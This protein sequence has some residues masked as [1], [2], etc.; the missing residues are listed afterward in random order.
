MKS[1]AK[2][3]IAQETTPKNDNSSEFKID[4][5]FLNRLEQM[6]TLFIE[7]EPHY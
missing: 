3:D 1:R 6:I 7:K 5:M 2:L 4:R